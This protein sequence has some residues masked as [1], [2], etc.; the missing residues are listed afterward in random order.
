LRAM[1]SVV[2]LLLVFICLSPFVERVAIENVN[3]QSAAAT[4]TNTITNTPTALI[5]NLQTPSTA[6]VENNV[7]VTLSVPY[8]G[9]SSLD[10][11]VVALQSSTIT[12]NGSPLPSRDVEMTG[13]AYSSPDACT[14]LPAI[15]MAL[16][17]NN[18]IACLIT[19]ASSSGSENLTFT[20]RFLSANTYSVGIF[21][22][23]I[24]PG[25]SVSGLAGLSTERFSLV[26]S[27]AAVSTPE[28]PVT[29]PTFLILALTVLAV[30]FARRQYLSKR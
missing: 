23:A 27:T 29:N 22:A 26:V 17:G 13:S 1:Y 25:E 3:T 6:T 14:Q 8:S 15:E 7:T 18:T 20:A 24:Y 30:L 12:V 5:S 4:V 28:F 16:L 9:V 2:S 10:N 11:I 21:A 19:P